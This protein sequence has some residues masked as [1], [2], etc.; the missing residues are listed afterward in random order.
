MATAANNSQ[1]YIKSYFAA[2]IE[3]AM[4]R[5]RV[6]LGPEALLLN[7]R[8]AP[9]EG[10]HLGECEA[11]FGTRP[12]PALPR[13]IPEAAV[14]PVAD[15]RQRV[16]DLRLRSARFARGGNRTS[17]DL[18]SGSLCAAGVTRALA[19]E[20]EGAVQQR[21][22]RREVVEI[23]RP[24]MAG[25]S[26]DVVVG[27][28]V[29]ELEGRFEVAPEI[30]RIAAVVGPAG[31]GKTSALV[32]LAVTRGL[33]ARRP[34]R[35]LS[36]DNY[37][38]AAADQLK[39]YAAILGVPFTLAET[40]LLLAQAIDAAPPETLLLIDTPGYAP[41]SMEDSGRELASFFENRQDIDTHLV[42]TATVRP[43]DLDRS[44]DLF[45]AFQPAKLLFT[46]LD[47]T[48]S[49][50]AMFCEAARS[51]L[52]LSFLSTGQV[53]PEDLEAAT[54]DRITASLVRGLPED[55]EAVA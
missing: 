48:D 44:V 23:G 22:R 21:L 33:M 16:K 13:C 55:L 12:A 51:G 49:T 47:E 54:K 30:G 45:R 29:E 14:Y 41:A 6:E 17:C 11:V 8:E 50:A 15:I 9:P 37:R 26:A 31:A 3:E 52:P 10:R 7:M 34:V 2:S 24:S 28:T 36:I 42:L 40:T 20:I 18:L 53:I 4:K 27:E 32:K 5:A 43:A 39:T 46:R 19:D 35:L 1:L 38:I 25:W